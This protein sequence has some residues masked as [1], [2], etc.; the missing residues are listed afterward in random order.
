MGLKGLERMIDSLPL[1]P[2]GVMHPVGLPS[3]DIIWRA[4]VNGIS[5][6]IATDVHA[7]PGKVGRVKGLA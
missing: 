2:G 3:P 1:W 5:L 7:H 4:E 6:A